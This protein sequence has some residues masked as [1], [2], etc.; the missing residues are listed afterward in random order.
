MPQDKNEQLNQRRYVSYLVMQVITSKITVLNAL[1]LF[2]ENTKDDSINTVFHALV[3]Y[4]ADED[5][6]ARDSLYAQEQDSYLEELA[7]ILKN[8]ENLPFNLIDEYKKYHD[9]TLISPKETKETI[10]EKLKRLINL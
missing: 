9:K 6:R 1:K 3:H 8:G 2:P 10:F 4:E 5:L 7:N